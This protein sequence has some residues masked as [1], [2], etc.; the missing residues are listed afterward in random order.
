M[1]FVS[2]NETGRSG[3]RLAR[4]SGRAPPRQLSPQATGLQASFC[5]DGDVFFAAQEKDGTF[6]YR[7]KEDGSGLHG[8]SAPRPF[9]LTRTGSTAALSPGHEEF[10]SR[11][12]SVPPR[13]GIRVSRAWW[14]TGS[15]PSFR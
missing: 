2:A 4:L 3:V 1:V 10:A 15:S 13:T 11:S 12:R 7:V 9:S 5:A 6:A 14:I 8:D